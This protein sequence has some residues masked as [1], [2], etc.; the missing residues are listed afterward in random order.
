MSG[1]LDGLLVVDLSRMLPGAVLSRQLLD[2]GARVVKVEEPTGD[3]MRLAPPHVDGVGAGFAALLRGAE[4]ACL[5]LRDAADAD[6]VRRLVSRADVLVESFRPGTL[7]RWGLGEDPLRDRNPALVWCSLSSFGPG[8]EARSRVAHDLNVAASTGL[9][10]L[11]GGGVPRVQVADVATG[12]LAASAVLAA[13]LERV[14]SGR[15]RRLDQSVVSGALPFLTWGLADAAVGGGSDALDGLLAG[16]APSYRIYRCADGQELA[17]AALEPKFWA[18]LVELLDRPALA[19][20]WLDTGPEGDE[21]GRQ[22]QDVFASRP[23]REWLDL[24]QGLPVSAVHEAA[25]EEAV[26]TLR[27]AGLVEDGV[28]G[29]WLPGVGTTPERPAPKLGEHTDAIRAEVEALG[30]ELGR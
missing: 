17:V 10:E 12:L 26:A 20:V 24:L 19:A 13:L 14:R 25:S 22:L 11:L 7:D 16:R 9:L 29:P 15:G 28:P 23:R 18:R 8:E 27:G 1:P 2:L 3:P 21:A 5:D 4:S 6:V 30:P